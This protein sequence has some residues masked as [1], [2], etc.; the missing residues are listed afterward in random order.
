M[1]KTRSRVVAAPNHDCQSPL[2]SSLAFSTFSVFCP[3]AD[4]G[5]AGA[6][7][8]API[9]VNGPG[10]RQGMAGAT[11][12]M[13]QGHGVGGMATGR[14]TVK[15]PSPVNVVRAAAWS[16]SALPLRPR[17]PHTATWRL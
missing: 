7:T 4:G 13:A 12:R 17:L 14:F 6:A 8:G 16:Q 15:L 3:N 5:A 9:T 1:V 10:T 2:P 11:A